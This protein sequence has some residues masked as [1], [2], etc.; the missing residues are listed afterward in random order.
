[1][2]DARSPM[3]D[4]R[5]PMPDAPSPF[6]SRIPIRIYFLWGRLLTNINNH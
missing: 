3:P 4:A 5:C 2:P 1:M 6:L